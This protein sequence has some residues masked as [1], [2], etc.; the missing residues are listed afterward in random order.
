MSVLVKFPTP[1]RISSTSL[2]ES[3]SLSRTIM[4]ESLDNA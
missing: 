1:V 2:I 3:F 4:F